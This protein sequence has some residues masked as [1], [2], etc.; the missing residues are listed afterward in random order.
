MLDM[1]LADQEASNF[2]CKELEEANNW[3]QQ[4][5]LPSIITQRHA[6]MFMQP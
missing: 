3:A 4:Q 5:V 6:C 1:I 2:A